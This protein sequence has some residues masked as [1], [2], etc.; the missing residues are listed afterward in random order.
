MNEAA[1]APVGY[2]RQ[3]KKNIW[4]GEQTLKFLPVRPMYLL[5]HHV[6]EQS[7]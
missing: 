3:A 4:R 7:Y 5:P 1:L 6:V 2:L